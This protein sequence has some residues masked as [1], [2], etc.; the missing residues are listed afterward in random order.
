MYTDY[1]RDT[2]QIDFNQLKKN[3]ILGERSKTMVGKNQDLEKHLERLYFDFVDKSELEFFHA[4]LIVHI[5]RKID[6][7]WCVEQFNKLWGLECEFLC[8]QLKARWLVSACDTMIDYPTSLDNQALALAAVLFTNTIKLYETENLMLE[9]KKY[10]KTAPLPREYEL[11]DSIT[12]Y[13]IG[14]GDMI[15]N[16]M[17]RIA[18]IG[19][20]DAPGYKILQE[21]VRRATHN[22]DTVY[23]RM[24]KRHLV[25]LTFW[26]DI[27]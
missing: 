24:L 16:M 22:N 23:S 20:S 18:S 11:F 2:Q 9:D 13:A 7:N 17:T 25:P 12:P 15:K 8:S 10:T 21:L 19:H 27:V 5:R 1:L 4:Y 6:L 14:K 26:G 3:I